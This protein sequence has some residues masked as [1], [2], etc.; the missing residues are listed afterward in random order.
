MMVYDVIVASTPH[1]L[2]IEV[3]RRIQDGWKPLGG[4]AAMLVD[5]EH[6]TYRIEKYAQAL[7]RE[8]KRDKPK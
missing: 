6:V 1:D 4:V 7:V 5:Y 2:A 3:N 8:Q